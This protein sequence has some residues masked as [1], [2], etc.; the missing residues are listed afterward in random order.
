MKK[1]TIVGSGI[2]AIAAAIEAQAQGAHVSLVRGHPGATALS[3]GAWDVAG[4]PTRYPALPWQE[5]PS[6]AESLQELIRRHPRHPYAI[7]SQNQACHPLPSFLEQMIERLSNQINLKLRGTLSK[8]IFVLNPLGSV[9]ATAYV[10]LSHLA[11]DLLAMQEARLLIVGF[12]GLPYFFS[13]QIAKILD[14]LRT[15]QKTNHLR[16]VAAVTIDIEGLPQTLSP[17]DLAGRLDSEECIETLC[18]LLLQ[19]AE[20]QKSTHIALPPVIGLKKTDRILSRLKEATGLAWFET[21]GLPPSVPGLRLQKAIDAFVEKNASHW[22]VLEG[23]AVGATSKNGR[24]E[25]LHVQHQ[26]KEEKIPVDRL[27]LATGRYLGGGIVKEKSFQEPILDLP[28]FIE[29]RQVREVFVG[30]VTSDKFLEDHPLFSAGVQMN[31]RLQPLDDRRRTIYE[32]V[33]VTGS[34]IGGYHAATQHCGMGVAVGTGTLAG[35]MA[36]L[37]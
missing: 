36:S 5:Y 25:S 9:K 31:E 29:D 21:A 26:D 37:L 6:Q 27:V 12:R 32:N 18:R 19:T 13:Q 11:G 3:S 20:R 1:V 30:K 8:N 34:L 15:R 14:I 10:P 2:A 23:H 35:R 22:T 24:V 4:L 16:D 28:I 17:I 33:W 7:L